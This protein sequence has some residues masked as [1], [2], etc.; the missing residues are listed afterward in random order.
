MRG[1]KK[2]VSWVCLRMGR[3]AL[4]AGAQWTQ[5]SGV[6]NQIREDLLEG[7]ED[8]GIDR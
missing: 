6:R 1:H 8:A 5:Q 7:R 3:E 2:G 4:V